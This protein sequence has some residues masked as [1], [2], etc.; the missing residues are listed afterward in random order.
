MADETGLIRASVVLVGKFNPAIFSPAWFSKHGL[1]SEEELAVAETTVVHPEITQ[2]KTGYLSVDV[3]QAKFTITIE[4]D[5]FIKIMDIVAVL[6]RKLLPH[7]PI[8]TIGIN[9]VEHFILDRWERR[10]SFG[11]AL[12]P[13]DP[14]GMWGQKLVSDKPTEVGGMI[15]LIMKEI[16]RP[17]SVGFRRVDV[18]PSVELPDKT[19]G[20]SV[21]VNDHREIEGE[22]I[23]G[24]VAAVDVLVEN[25]E[26]SIGESR[27]IV[28]DLLDFA[29]ACPV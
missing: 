27:K 5:P 7:T 4:S 26:L 9:Y 16:Y 11:R 22:D 25:F 24:A 18:Q 23:D 15:A 2:F 29:K 3:Q 28:S 6:F 21:A 19:T 14:W 1:I 10:L 20:V 8:K 17:P 13:I 12:A